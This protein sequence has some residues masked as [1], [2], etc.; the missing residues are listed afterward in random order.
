VERVADAINEYSS[1]NDKTHKWF[2]TNEGQEY[3]LTTLATMWID[4]QWPYCVNILLQHRDHVQAMLLVEF[5]FEVWVENLIIGTHDN[6][7]W[8]DSEDLLHIRQ[9]E[10]VPHFDEEAMAIYAQD[11]KDYLARYDRDNWDQDRQAALDGPAPIMADT[12]EWDWNDT[13]T[14]RS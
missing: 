8:P 14:T 6:G 7:W 11:R 3:I 9:H 4:I 10:N 1:E 13:A 2:G 5:I 12:V